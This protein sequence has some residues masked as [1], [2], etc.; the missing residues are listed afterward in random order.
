MRLLL[1]THTLI[2]WSTS[3]ENLP[4]RVLGLLE[5]PQNDLLLSIAS[6]W[7]MQ[8]KL[9][10]GKLKLGKPLSGLIANQQANNELKILPIALPHVF[11]LQSLPDLH[12]DPF[13]RIMIAQTM[14]ENLPFVSCDVVLDGYSI[15]R[16]W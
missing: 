3:S 11:A 6:V 9:Q 4:E 12:R 10:S 2:W 1:D 16:L 8:I 13:D 14:V 15:Q 5:D 7:E